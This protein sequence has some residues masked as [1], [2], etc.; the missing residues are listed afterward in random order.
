M[1]E[2]FSVLVGDIEAAHMGHWAV[3]G[4]ETGVSRP[5]EK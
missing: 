1:L 5:E 2:R 3:P 4:D